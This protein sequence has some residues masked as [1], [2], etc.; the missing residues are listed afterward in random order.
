MSLQGDGRIKRLQDLCLD[1]ISSEWFQVDRAS[2]IK[3]LPECMRLE[4]L[5]SVVKLG[6]LTDE[7]L[8]FF[9]CQG[10]TRLPLQ[11]LFS[12]RNSSLKQIGYLCP[13]LVSLDLSRC[14]QITN[15]VVQ[16]VLQGCEALKCIRLDQCPRITDSAFNTNDSPFAILFGALSLEVISL[17]G[18]PQVTGALV[19]YL[20]KVCRRLRHLD[21]S[22]CKR[23]MKEN[24]QEIFTACSQLESLNL[25]FIDHLADD[26]FES[27]PCANK[28][29]NAPSLE[30]TGTFSECS[31]AVSENDSNYR[32]SSSPGSMKDLK[33]LNL[34][35]CNITDATLSRV[36]FNCQAIVSL[37]LSNCVGI[38]DEGVAALARAAAWPRSLRE[39]GLRNCGRLTDAVGAHLAR[40]RRLRALD[41]GWCAGITD[42]CIVEI[43]DGECANSI[44]KLQLNWCH[45]VTAQ[46]FGRLVQSCRKLKVLDIRGCHQIPQSFAKGLSVYFG[47]QVQF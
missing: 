33:A 13:Q 28:P 41:L 31:T 9:L 7:S 44:E 25:A 43:A 39:L 35:R 3:R 36:S 38:T 14:T 11:G 30:E 22:Q 45:K 27:L 47:V 23:I 17:A 12:I 16:S 2:M 6:K 40:G 46:S 1:T 34:G 37:Q 26:A 24:V 32:F 5:E 21:L 10:T 4:A 15:S 18:C 29:T 19:H 8:S 42:A 20:R